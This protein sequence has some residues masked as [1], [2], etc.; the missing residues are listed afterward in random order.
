MHDA[1][2]RRSFPMFPAPQTEFSPYAA[3]ASDAYPEPLPSGPS[4][5][6]R[7]LTGLGK[8]AY[9]LFAMAVIIAIRVGIRMFFD[10]LN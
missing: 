7:F 9:F 1:L 8:A 3:P 2:N 5:G 4:F 10:S 6:S